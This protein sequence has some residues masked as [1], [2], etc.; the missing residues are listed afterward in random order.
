MKWGTRYI[1]GCG[2][3][4]AT[5]ISGGAGFAAEVEPVRY[6]IEVELDPISHRLQASQRVRWANTTTTPTDELWFH[7]YLNAFSSSETTF[8]RELGS[9]TLRNWTSGRPDWGWIR[10]DS[11]RYQGEDLLPALVFERPDDDNAED[12]TVARLVLPNPVPPGGIVELEIDFEAQLPWIIARTGFVDDFHFV[13]QWFPK[14]G[15]FEGER[16]WN[17][18]QFHAESEF[19]ADFGS[20]EVAITA[21][22]GWVVGATGWQM[23]TAPVE[24]GVRTVFRARRVHDFAWCAA[25]SSLMEVVETDFDPGR[26]VP[27]VWL[28]RAQKLLGLSAADLELPP[29]RLRLI[30][31]RSQAVLVPRMLRAARLGIA[32]FGLFYGPYPYPQ[33]TIVSPPR[34]AEEAGGMEYPTF[35]TTGADRLHAYPPF[36][37]SSDI[38]TVTVHEFGHQYFQGMLASNEFEE[39]WLDEGVTTFAEN[40]C[41]T[42]MVTDG[43]APQIRRIPFWGTERLALVAPSLPITVGRRAWDFRRRWHYYLAS[44]FK[45]SVALRTVEGMIGPE[46]MA[47]G[48]RAYVDRFRFGHPTG[49]DLVEALSDAGNQDLHWF[50]DQAIHGDATPDWR[51]LAVDQRRQTTRRGM[52][53]TASGWSPIDDAEAG[54]ADFEDQDAAG[55]DDPRWDVAVE[56]GRKGDLVAP[57]EVELTWADGTSERKT[58]NGEERWVRWRF[59]RPQRLDQVVID[60]DG[61]WALET[62]RADNYWRDRPSGAGGPLWWFPGVLRLVGRLVAP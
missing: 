8:M 17:C 18:H 60:P 14:L 24:R 5:A 57:V 15:V 56:I 55:I 58:W 33:L 41:L 38:E 34:G 4:V 32:W 3:V 2:L 12:F 37:W 30:V 44:Y 23:S 35:I 28:E 36:S 16:G 1:V 22:D 52:R 59:D 11:L 25:P 19:F 13:G 6:E 46:A 10:I 51:V 53:W 39:G 62:Q 21:P 49:D 54:E 29:M 43:L 48:M 31:P 45:T 40:S 7:L 9:G 27:V 47:A 20:Y 26:D 61:V 42:A 50:F